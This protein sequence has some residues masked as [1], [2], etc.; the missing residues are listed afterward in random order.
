MDWLKNNYLTLVAIVVGLVDLVLWVIHK[1]KH[2][3]PA[4][5][6]A[7]KQAKQ[8]AKHSKHL[9]KLNAEIEKIQKKVKIKQEVK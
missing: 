2:T 4:I 6:K 9:E 1:F 5:V 3:D 7:K 8:L